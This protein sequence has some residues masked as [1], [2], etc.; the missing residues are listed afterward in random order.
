[1]IMKRSVR[2]MKPL[3]FYRKTGMIDLSEDQI[4]RRRKELI[5]KNPSALS[6]QKNKRGCFEWFLD[7]NH[8]YEFN[9]RR[10]KKGSSKHGVPDIKKERLFN[11]INYKDKAP[12]T[13]MLNYSTEI[14]INFKD[15][16]DIEYYEHFAKELFIRN[17][18]NLYFVVE[19]DRD[20]YKHIHIGSCGGFEEILIICDYI[21]RKVCKRENDAYMKAIKGVQYETNV[22]IEPLIYDAGFQKYIQKGDDGLGGVKIKFLN[23]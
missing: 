18:D 17:Y 19:I 22:H 9:R 13:G 7:Y 23:V 6:F 11:S 16:Y 20:G 5:E 4:K 10:K 14:S 21:T 12:A 15:D 8:L 3:S 2:I 1:M